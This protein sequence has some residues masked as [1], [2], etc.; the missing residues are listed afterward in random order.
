MLSLIVLF[1]IHINLYLA[2]ILSC[3]LFSEQ[4]PLLSCWTTRSIKSFH[5]VLRMYIIYFSLRKSARLHYKC[6]L[7]KVVDR[8][9][10]FACMGYGGSWGLARQLLWHLCNTSLSQISVQQAQV[11]LWDLIISIQDWDPVCGSQ[12][13]KKTWMLQDFQDY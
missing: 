8:H 2:L 9:Y 4:L 12:I 6:I 3:S 11:Q 5:T 10:Y 1:I 7:H 13:K